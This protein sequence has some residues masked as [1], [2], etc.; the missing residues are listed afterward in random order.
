MGAGRAAHAPG[1]AAATFPASG[2]PAVTTMSAMRAG[3]AF[4]AQLD[5]PARRD[6]RVPR[7]KLAAAPLGFVGDER[8]M[9]RQRD[10]QDVACRPAEQN[11]TAAPAPMSSSQIPAGEP[12]SGEPEKRLEQR[13]FESAD[14]GGAARLVRNHERVR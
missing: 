4:G 9:A 10:A 11:V 5:A 14:L 13:A 7:T 8:D 12:F 2:S 3:A 6:E 1:L